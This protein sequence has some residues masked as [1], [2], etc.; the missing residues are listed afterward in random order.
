MEGKL[1]PKKCNV[2]RITPGATRCGD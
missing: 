2:T 1:K